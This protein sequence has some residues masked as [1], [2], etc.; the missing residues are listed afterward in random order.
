MLGSKSAARVLCLL[1]TA[2]CEGISTRHHS[3]PNYHISASSHFSANSR[4]WP[5]RR[6]QTAALF[7]LALSPDFALH[8][9]APSLNQQ[10]SASSLESRAAELASRTDALLKREADLD[11]RETSVSSALAK[12]KAAEERAKAAE[13]AVAGR[14][15]AAKE[16]RG[17]FTEVQGGWV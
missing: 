4:L 11:K 16:V 12:A 7:Y 8:G 14:E 5:P 1:L 15:K 9:H 13:K 2:S 3:L 10:A 6:F 17:A